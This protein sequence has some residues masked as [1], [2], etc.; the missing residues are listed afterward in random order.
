M[1]DTVVVAL[2]SCG[3]VVV[4]A[5]IAFLVS[6]RQTR[7]RLREIDQKYTDKLFERRIDSYPML[8]AL[9]GGLGYHLKKG[10]LSKHAVS[11]AKKRLREWDAQYA[12]YA[13]PVVTKCLV[14]LH[15]RMDLEVGDHDMSLLS[16]VELNEI[17]KALI[18]LE[19]ALKSEV[20]VF[21]AEGFH[22][23]NEQ[24]FFGELIDYPHSYRLDEEELREIHKKAEQNVTADADKPRR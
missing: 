8:Y 14:D 7:V 16:D 2:I 18:A 12:L 3:G 13:S 6:Y 22:K 10:E 23:I 17:W 15:K 24:R 11:R 5:L 20:G 4:S 1:S 19:V 21:A 9:I